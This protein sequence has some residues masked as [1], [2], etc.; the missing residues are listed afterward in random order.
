MAPVLVES[1]CFVVD[2]G[3]VD[4]DGAE[5]DVGTTASAGVAAGSLTTT[6]IVSTS[7]PLRLVAA[8]RYWMLLA[9]QER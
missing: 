6:A 4:V 1:T 7:L 8:C 5:G 2:G 3:D 9:V